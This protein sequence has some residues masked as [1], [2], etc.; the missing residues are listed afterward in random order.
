MKNHEIE[1]YC[2]INNSIECENVCN[3]YCFVGMK[4]DESTSNI[5]DMCFEK[6]VDGNMNN[7]MN[8]IDTNSVPL[9]LSTYFNKKQQYNEFKKYIYM[10]IGN[11][12]I[13]GFH[14]LGQ[15]YKNIKLYDL[16]KKFHMMM[17]DYYNNI[18]S[19][20]M[21]GHYYQD[22]EKNYVEMKKYYLMAFRN[23]DHDNMINNPHLSCSSNDCYIKRM[24]ADALYNFAYHY[25]YIEK[26]YD[27]MKYYY[28]LSIEYDCDTAMYGLGRYYRQIKNYDE[29]KKYH[30]MAIMKRNERSMNDLAFYYT[31]IDKNNELSQKY[32]LMAIEHNSKSCVKSAHRYMN[33]IKIYYSLSNKDFFVDNLNND[34]KKILDDF[35]N[36]CVSEICELCYMRNDCVMRNDLFICG[37]CH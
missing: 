37:L 29:M 10:A 21:L 7:I 13:R 14:A 5:C 36:N 3:R 22:I 6:F 1:K 26:N 25:R 2:Y 18:C 35:L 30:L 4:I 15:H 9:F 24:I 33:I 28:F 20:C 19:M 8:S 34:N 31:Y 32:C 23:L 17:I 16:M 11:G 12:N 27:E